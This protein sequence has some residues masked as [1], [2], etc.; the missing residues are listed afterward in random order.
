MAAINS[1]GRRGRSRLGGLVP[2]LALW[3][4]GWHLFGFQQ[5]DPRAG[6]S[7]DEDRP[8]AGGSRAA[9][10][11]LVY[12]LNLASNSS[13]HWERISPAVIGS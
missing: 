9:R 6:R 5:T 8:G 12:G 1:N 2:H 3:W 10:V 4:S 11:R 7:P 13:D